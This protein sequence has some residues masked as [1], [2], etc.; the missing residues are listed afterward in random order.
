MDCE[1]EEKQ[2]EQLMN[3]E[4]AEK[5]R[6][7][8]AGQCLEKDIGIDAA[9]FFSKNSKFWRK[10]NDSRSLNFRPG[11]NLSRKLWNIAERKLKSAAFPK[12]KCNL[13]I[14]YKRPE[15]IKS[16]NG[17]QYPDWRHAYFRYKIRPH[18]QNTLAE[19][20]RKTSPNAIVVYA[21]ASF[22]KIDALWKNAENNHLVENSN[23]VPPHTLIG[24]HCYTFINGTNGGKAC[25]E[26]V[27]VKGI[28]LLNELNKLIEEIDNYED[29]V[30][31]M[32]VLAINLEKTIHD[33][34]NQE[35]ARWFHSIKKNMDIAEH[36]LARSLATIFA[37]NFVTNTTW[38]IGYRNEKSIVSNEN[39]ID[40]RL[41]GLF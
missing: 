26:P 31:F 9:L 15:S 12:F 6:I 20:E 1:Y 8:P 21:C 32:S 13:F 10:W 18:Q 35:T 34:E 28:E 23:F 22:S 4:L 29:N 25:S 38:A 17:K 39:E 30:Q 16:P 5:G 37:F 36:R 3:Y 14:Q 33:L 19:L 27:K 40:G 7:Y 41:K 11:V 2:Y 24:H